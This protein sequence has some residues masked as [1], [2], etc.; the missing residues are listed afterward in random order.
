MK[1]NTEHRIAVA[2]LGL[3]AVAAFT[4]AWIVAAAID[5][6]TWE[7]GVNAIS[8]LGASDSDARYYMTIGCLV[9][10]FMLAGFGVC[11]ATASTRYKNGT[12]YSVGGL[13]L[14]LAGIFLILNGVISSDVGNG[15]AHTF[16]CYSFS[17]LT[18]FA[19]ASYAVGTWKNGQRL[20]PGFSVLVSCIV[21]AMAVSWDFEMT[22]CWA[23]VICLLWFTLFCIDIIVVEVKR[24]D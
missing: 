2:W 9:T 7:F 17:F 5:S 22:E 15:N 14:L 13:L 20:F 23:A 4:I 19:F 1:A 18:F 24:E 10:G 8:D 16:A 21:I 3:I 11:T 6:S 12:G